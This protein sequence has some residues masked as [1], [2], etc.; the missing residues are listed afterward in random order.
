MIWWHGVSSDDVHLIVER[1]PARTVAAR[2]VATVSIPGRNGDYIEQQDA[3]ENVIQ[4]YEVYLSG[5]FHGHLPTVSRS[6]AQWLMVKGY[7]RLEDS[8]D[9]DVFRFAHVQGGQSF[10]S[11]LNEFGRATIEF[12]C[13]PQ[14]FLKVG[15]LF[16]A[17]T[18]G[19]TLINPTAF[20]ALPQL[21]L[22]GEGG[23][24][25]SVE[26][27]SLTLSDVNETMIDCETC[28]VYRGLENLNGTTSGRFFRLD[29]TAKISWAGGI[30]GVEIRPR[31]WCL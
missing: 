24:T 19:Q 8:Y 27:R 10:E 30:T 13:K 23:G 29:S 4:P 31:W 14:R 16:R 6:A 17:V 25:V 11:Y 5:E 2:K 28:Q 26:E 7:Q 1:Y 20:T 15:D 22:H 21:L 12:N 18:N 9:L 3:F